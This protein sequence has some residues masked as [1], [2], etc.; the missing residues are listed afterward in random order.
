MIKAVAV[1]GH[2]VFGIGGFMAG[3]HDP[4][5]QRQVFKLVGLQQGIV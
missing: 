1:F 4:V 2:P 3:R 5:A